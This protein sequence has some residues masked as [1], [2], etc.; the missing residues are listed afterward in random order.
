M[1][2]IRNFTGRYTFLSNFSHSPFSA[3]YYGVDEG[4]CY[5]FETVEHYFQ[6][7]KANTNVER[8][9]IRLAATPGLAKKAGRKCELRSDWDAIKIPVM[10]AGLAEK[11]VAGKFL[12]EELLLT[13]DAHLI[14]GNTWGDRFWGVDGHGENWLG[15]LLMA[16]RGFLRSL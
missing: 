10:R 9:I 4:E 5:D 15:W 14:E 8:E 1:I 12:A 6:A 16:Q 11:F 2:V 13:G 7:N 3:P